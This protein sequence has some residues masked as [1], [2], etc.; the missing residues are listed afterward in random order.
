MSGQAVGSYTT[1]IYTLPRP[2]PAFGK[3]I[4]AQSNANSY[5]NGLI[6]QL[7]KRYSTWFQG[8]L[9]YTWSHTIDDDIGGAAGGVGG[10]SGILFVPSFVT[11]VFNGDERGEKGSAA[12]DERHR[13]VLSG[14]MNPKFTHGDSAFDKIRNQRMAV[15]GDLDV[16]LVLPIGANCERG[17][18]P[19]SSCGKRAPFDQHVEW[20][21]RS[22]ACSVRI[23][24]RFKR[25]ANL[26]D[27]CPSIAH[28]AHPR[29]YASNAAV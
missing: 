21:G 16:R 2:N 12:T 13:L 10:S 24:F 29:A 25:G 20:I 9:S 28:L 5:Y 26:S 17:R 11:S 8:N 1:P 18:E 6:V 14:V 3:I 23:D 4:L 19:E 22:N 15:V 7:Q 27:G